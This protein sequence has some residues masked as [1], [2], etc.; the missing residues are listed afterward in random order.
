[1]KEKLV[2]LLLRLLFYPTPELHLSNEEKELCENLYANTMNNTD[3]TIIYDLPVPKYKFLHYLISTKSI[4]LHGSN[5]PEIDLFEP[6]KQTLYSGKMDEAVFATKDPIWSSFYAVFNK[7]NLIGSIRNGSMSGDGKRN[8]HFYSL[9]NRILEPK[10]I[11][12]TVYILPQQTFIPVTEGPIQ[13]NEWIS[14]ESVKP[15][16]KM[17]VEPEDFYF[18]DKVAVHTDRETLAKSWLFYKLRTFL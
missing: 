15:I 4:V 11:K 12:G 5:N 10:W 13:F 7:S 16:A 2:D 14:R 3:N 9:S 6:R 17:N 1:M 18:L 8:Y